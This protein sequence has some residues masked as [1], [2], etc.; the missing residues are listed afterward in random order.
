M[1]LITVWD[2]KHQGLADARLST[3]SPANGDGGY[4]VLYKLGHC[5]NLS[6]V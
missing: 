3:L 4:P 6:S 1:K 2:R 5:M